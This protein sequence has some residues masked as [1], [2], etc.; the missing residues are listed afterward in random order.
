MIE[1]LRELYTHLEAVEEY[2]S[3]DNPELF[4]LVGE[5]RVRVARE[6]NRIYMAK[7]R[8]HAKLRRAGLDTQNDEY[9][10]VK[11]RM[12]AKLWLHDKLW[13]AGLDT[14]TTN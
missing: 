14:D 1:Y 9:E 7:R 10:M 6:I 3:D 5:E 11:R 12:Y 13:R 2:A 4:R 8:I